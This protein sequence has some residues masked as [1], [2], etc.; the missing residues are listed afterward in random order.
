[1]P[2]M[3]I[4]NVS[5]MLGQLTSTVKSL[6]DD[7]EALRSTVATLNDHMNQN[8]GGMRVLLALC[9]GSAALGGTIVAFAQ[10]ALSHMHG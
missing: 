6:A 2:F 3:E 1:M 9:S 8:K 5:L 4:D 10:W 7:V